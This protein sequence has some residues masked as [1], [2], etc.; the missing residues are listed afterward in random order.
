MLLAQNLFIDIQSLL[1]PFQRLGIITLAKI[2]PCYVI[3]GC[4]GI[5]M[6]LAQNLFIDIQSLPV[7]FQRLEIICNNIIKIRCAIG[8]IRC[9]YIFT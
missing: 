9:E 4:C 3:V 7:P 8:Y 2:N 5:R 1:V 6:L